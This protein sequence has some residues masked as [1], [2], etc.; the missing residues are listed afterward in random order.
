MKFLTSLMFVGGLLV[1][2]NGLSDN[3]ETLTK[4]HLRSDKWSD[5]D[6]KMEGRIVGGEQA[7]MKDAPWQVMLFIKYSPMSP[8]D[9]SQSVSSGFYTHL[10]CPLQLSF[11]RLF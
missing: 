10:K 9:N 8:R 3:V 2:A 11:V 5:A 7:G 6:P 1:L 4:A